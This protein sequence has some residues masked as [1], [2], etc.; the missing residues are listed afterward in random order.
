MGRLHDVFVITPG[1]SLFAPNRVEIQMSPQDLISLCDQMELGV[2]VASA[3]EAYEEQVG[4]YGARFATAGRPEVCV[5]AD[6]WIPRG[7]YRLRQ[8]HPATAAARHERPDVSYD[9]SHAPGLTSAAPPH[10]DSDPDGWARDEP[11]LARTSVDALTVVDAGPATVMEK[12]LAPVP[13]LRL[14]TG[15]SVTQTRMPGAR[16]GRGHVELA[17][18]DV[19]TISR[20]HARFAFADGRWW[21]T[22]LGMNGLTV[23]GAP[24]VTEHPLSDGDIIGWGSRPD[25]LVSRVEIG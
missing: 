7:R 24:A 9:M 23:N 20:E 13:V 14:V 11:A 15:D 8:G 10:H 4:R 5:V 21:V 1:G 6:E 16:A 17:L 18:P 3:T 25:A 2:I 19:P 22:N 12:T